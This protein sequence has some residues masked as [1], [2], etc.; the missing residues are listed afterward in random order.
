MTIGKSS[1]A[2]DKLDPFKKILK[3]PEDIIKLTRDAK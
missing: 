3:L 2:I 1:K